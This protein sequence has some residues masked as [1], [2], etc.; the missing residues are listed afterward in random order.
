MTVLFCDLVDSSA[1]AVQLDPE[2]FA[3]L[4]VSYR[5]HCAAAVRHNG[6]YISRYVG[7]GVLGCFGYPRAIGRDAQAAVACGLRIASEISAL[8]AATSLPGGRELAVRIGIETGVVIAGRLG[9]VS[10]MELDALVGAA[11]NTAARLQQEAPPNGVVIGE[12]THELVAE[13]FACEELPTQSLKHLVPPARAFVVRGETTRA[14]R[15]RVLARRRAPLVGRATEI[16]SIFERWARASAGRGQTVLLSGEAGIG[17]S[18]LAQEL[19]DHIADEPHELIVLTCTPPAAGTAFFPAIQALRDALAVTVE[20]AGGGIVTEQALTELVAEIGLESGPTRALLARAIGLDL[21][22]TDLAPAAHRRLLL[23]ALQAWLLHRAGDQTLLILAEDL[24]WSDPSLLELLHELT[25]IIPSRRA[26]LLATYRTDLVLP[27]PDRSTTLRVTLPPL[28]RPDAGRLLAALAGNQTVETREAILAR[29]DGVPLFLEE[30]TLAAG[31]PAVPR[32][33]QQLFAARLDSLGE[34]KRLAQC[35]AVLAPRL[36]P[37]LLGSLAEL[38]DALVDK[39]LTRL[40]DME[41]LVRD[42]AVRGGH[43]YTFRHALLQEAAS[44]SLLATDRRALHAHTAAI[45]TRL[46]PDLV[47]QQPEVLA[48]HHVSGGELAAAVPLYASAARRALASAALE[49]AETHVRRGLSATSALPPAEAA[50]ADLDLNVLLG[51][52]LIARRG[53]ANAA[54]QEAFEGALR[55]AKRIREESRVLPALRGL[56]SFYQVRGPL[57]RAETICNRLLAGVKGSRDP[58]ILVDAWR[59]RGWNH[60]CMGR[61]AEAE[62]DFARALNAFNGARTEEHIAVAG[63]DPQVLALANLCW[64]APPRYGLA[65]AVQR[66]HA[67]AAAARNSPHPVSACYGMLFAA[68]VLQQAERLDEALDLANNALAVAA[69]KGFAYWVAMG[70]VATGY[71]Q[72]IRRGNLAAGREAIA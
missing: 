43:V 55:A 35:A 64:L 12:A 31:T 4:L 26:M 67:A 70:K 65:E 17:K 27:W 30:F 66:A 34:A 68:L 46:R 51:H 69:E 53:Y 50:E 38:P 5:E 32:T 25:D 7:D 47:E 13:D 39:G 14:G 44:Q 20:K 41:V 62:E 21:G 16:R 36:E 58:C 71:D 19:V 40:V 10:A 61:L 28:E 56:A 57:S 2:E 1:L 59:R 37:D 52:V 11:P 24:H 29:S 18:R 22:P 45:L 63:H 6:G 23:Q 33:L 3:A 48:E 72:V 42:S 60:G 9:P 8:A 15:R 49:E 54:V